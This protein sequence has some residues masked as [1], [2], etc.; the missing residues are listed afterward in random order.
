[1]PPRGRFKSSTVAQIQRPHC[2]HSSAPTLSRKPA[3]RRIRRRGSDTSHFISPGRSPRRQASSE[4]QCRRLNT[5]RQPKLPATPQHGVPRD[6]RSR[7]GGS[8]T[9]LGRRRTWCRLRPP[10][11]ARHGGE[12]VH[13]EDA[14]SPPRPFL[15]RL[16]HATTVP[17]RNT[18]RT[19]SPCR[20]DNVSLLPGESVPTV[21]SPRMAAPAPTPCRRVHE[22]D[23]ALRHGHADANQR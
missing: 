23:T 16:P 12:A 9:A 20:P 13:L 3:N 7:A 14:P 15:L 4:C 8:L 19:F 6:G 11:C 21:S 5:L 1:M 17:R 22:R 18:R 2:G 10:A